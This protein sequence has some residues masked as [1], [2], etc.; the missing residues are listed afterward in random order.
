MMVTSNSATTAAFSSDCNSERGSKRSH[1]YN[2][3]EGGNG[4]AIESVKMT[5]IGDVHSSYLS[6]ESESS[7]SEGINFLAK[8]K[9]NSSSRLENGF[10]DAKFQTHQK[11]CQ[12][13]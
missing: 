7:D 6:Q 1:N 12:R 2:L 5:K 8:F 3:S 11:N 4:S 13:P 9:D 10:V